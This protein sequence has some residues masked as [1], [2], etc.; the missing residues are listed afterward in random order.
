MSLQQIDTMI[1]FVIARISD[2]PNGYR[3]VVRDMATQWPDVTG[4]QI[5]FVLVSAAHAF[6]RVFEVPS[7]PRT[8]V[9]QTFRIAALLASDLFALQQRSNFAPTGR[10]LLSY[11]QESDPY[12]LTL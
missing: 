4:A 10:D 5:V 7:E 11:W 8:E 2:T 1:D 3:A 6:E 9:Q 12:F